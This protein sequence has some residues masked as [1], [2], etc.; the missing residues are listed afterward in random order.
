MA[1][2][3]GIS[4]LEICQCP[5][6]KPNHRKTCQIDRKNLICQKKPNFIWPFFKHKKAKGVKKSQKLQ[7]WP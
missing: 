5:E 2:W 4:G 6:K 3:L 7:I 1:H